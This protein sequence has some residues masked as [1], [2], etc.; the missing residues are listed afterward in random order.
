[1]TIRRGLIPEDV[2][3][4]SW[5]AELS[6]SPDGQTVA[7]TVKRVQGNAY[8]TDVYLANTN[9]GISVCLTDGSGNASSLAWSPDS[10]KLAFVFS[11]NEQSI[12][13]YSVALQ[14]TE[15]HPVTGALPQ[16]LDWS[17]D[18]QK[19]A[20]TRWT[21]MRHPVER[22]PQPG[23]PA[24]NMKVI[25]RLRYKQEG[26][27]FVQD[28]FSQL[29]IYDLQSQSFQQITDSEC[30]YSE[31][32][33]SHAG[34]KIAFTATAREQ[35][36]PLGQGQILIYD[37][38]TQTITSLL[39]NWVGSARSPVWGDNDASIAFAGHETPP[40]TNRRIFTIP[41]IADVASKK[42]HA[43]KP[44]LNE[45]IGNYAVSDSRAGLSNITVKWPKGSPWIYF[46]LTVKGATQLCRLSTKGDFEV[47]EQG[48][49]VVFEYSPSASDSVAFGRADP[50]N[51]G[52]LYIKQADTVT[53]LTTLNPWLADHQLSIPEEYYFAGLEDA[54]IHSWIMKPHAFDEKKQ[55]PGIVYV[56]CSMFS[57]DFSHEFQCHVTNGYVLTYFNQRGTTAGYGQAWTRASEGDQGGKD[58][59]ET[60]LGVEHFASRPYID[61]NRLGVTGGSCG[62]FMTNWIVGH[63]D[64]FKAAVTQRS[65]SNQISMAGVSDFGPEMTRGETSVDAVAHF[66][67]AWRQS[68][69]AYAS[70]VNTPLLIIHSDQDYR[71]PLEQAEQLFAALRWM[72]KEVEMVIFEG[73]GHGLSRNGRPGNRIERLRRI[74]GWF[75]S[76]LGVRP[77]V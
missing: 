36:I 22:G 57:W 45:E 7:Y 73:E 29:W 38:A 67:A 26:V 31:P 48:D 64:R 76:H 27:G 30:D 3:K 14:E 68:P 32:K 40:P 47:V 61:A 44:D 52:E 63:T 13:V 55:Y 23:I 35:N 71:C 12:C 41:Y 21:L 54:N 11:G 19:L 39:D 37:D 51:P 42:A 53:R 28:S 4:F 25:R 18:N 34:S 50:T 60:M 33:W 1:M 5:L 58:Y 74:M 66:E 9:S 24:A 8:T 6:L 65:I 56:H 16:G 15:L 2:L 72:N 69:L 62:G 43:L 75:E 10:S 59:E 46:L 17:A 20:F 49:C 70:Q 77:T